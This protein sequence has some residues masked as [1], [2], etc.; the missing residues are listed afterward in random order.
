MNFEEII[1]KLKF[2]HDASIRYDNNGVKCDRCQRTNITSCYGYKNIDICTLCFNDLQNKSKFV[3]FIQTNED[4]LN[5]VTY[6]APETYNPKLIDNT[7]KI[8]EIKSIPIT[9]MAREIYKPQIRSRMM[10]EIYNKPTEKFID[11]DE[12]GYQLQK[13]YQ[14][15]NFNKTIKQV[16]TLLGIN[17]WIF[18]IKQ[19]VK[20]NKLQKVDIDTVY[21]IKR[22][23]A[24]PLK[25]YYEHD[26]FSQNCEWRINTNP[27]AITFKVNK[28]KSG[29][30]LF[31]QKQKLCDLILTY[32]GDFDVPDEYN[33][34]MNLSFFN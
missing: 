11:F 18:F 7:N 31:I 21:A 3:S 2:Y 32:D 28:T 4:K 6:M 14:N 27:N 15:K 24:E 16:K 26:K 5:N 22:L 13:L 17:N 9:Y 30:T 20:E 10:H 33:T 19:I 34:L 29:F 23:F 12:F 8:P 25:E 1:E